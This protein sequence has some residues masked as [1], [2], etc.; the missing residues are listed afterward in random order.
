VH[1]PF[2]L[3]RNVTLLGTEYFNLYLIKGETFAIMGKEGAR[4]HLQ[5]SRQ[6]IEEFKAFVLEWINRGDS[7][8]EITKEVTER[9]SKGFLQ[10]FPP[11]DNYRLWR[12][13]VQR[14]LEHFGIEIEERG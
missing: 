5:R 13:L 11:E 4:Y 8:E 14:T 10:F 7:I 12:L 1:P 9:Y 3:T 6:S 2:Q